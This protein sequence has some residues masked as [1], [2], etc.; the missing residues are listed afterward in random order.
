[1]NKVAKSHNLL[2]DNEDLRLFRNA[3]Y[4]VCVGPN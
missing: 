4:R 2:L 3:I 1:M